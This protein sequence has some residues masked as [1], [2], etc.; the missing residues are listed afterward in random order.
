[1]ELVLDGQYGPIHLQV[2]HC[3]PVGRGEGSPSLV[4][5]HIRGQSRCYNNNDERE[6]RKIITCVPV[7]LQVPWDYNQYIITWPPVVLKV[8]KSYSRS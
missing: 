6:R 3:Q 1:M 8:S 7:G 4:M 2:N 5:A